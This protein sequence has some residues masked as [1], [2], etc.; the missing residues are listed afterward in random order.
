MESAVI[1]VKQIG[2]GS[3]KQRTYLNGKDGRNRQRQECVGGIMHETP[4]SGA[5][6]WRTCIG[7]LQTMRCSRRDKLTCSMIVMNPSTSEKF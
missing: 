7:I 5:F 6:K 4:C 3:R 2:R 1:A